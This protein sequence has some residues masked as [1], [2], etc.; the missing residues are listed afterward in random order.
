MAN[1]TIPSE[2][3]ADGA[4]TSAKLD[5]NIAVGGTLTVTGDANFD[6]NTLFVD[7]SAN[8]VGIGTPSP[9]EKLSVVG[10]HVSVGDST[11]VSGTEFLLEGYREIYNGAKY[12]NTSIRT[13]YNTGSNASDMLFY[14]ASSGTNTAERLRINSSGSVLVGTTDP[15]VHIGTTSGAVITSAG[16]GFFAVS[17]NSPIYANRLTNDGAI[18]DLRKNG[19]PVGSIGTIAGYMT[20]GTSDTGVVFHSGEDNIQPW[21][22]STNAGRDNAISLGAHNARFKDL[23]LSGGVYLGGTSAANKLDDYEEGTWT[24][25]LLTGT[26]SFSGGTYTKVGRLVTANFI[27]SA[28]SDTTSTNTIKISLPFVAE[29]AD[30]AIGLSTLTQNISFTNITG[31]YSDSTSTFSI[32]GASASGYVFMR[33]NNLSSSSDMY[34]VITYMSA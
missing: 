24:P 1:T 34:A 3:I 9:T 31:G 18:I 19:S 33:H 13:T 4:I 32:Y 26:A 27:M 17:G 28:P 25:T 11:G 7:A 15:N 22:V 6:S 29:S 2:L 10:G 5:T 8:A 20:V 30:R 12:G 21:N 14:T 23:Y 16:F